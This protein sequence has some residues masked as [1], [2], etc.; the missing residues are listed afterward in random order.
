MEEACAARDKRCG[1]REAVECNFK[2]NPP[3]NLQVNQRTERRRLE[4]TCVGEGQNGRAAR[5]GEGGRGCG[6]EVVVAAVWEE[7]VGREGGRRRRCG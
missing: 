6:E 7:G 4:G 1:T 3:N 5:M 2:I